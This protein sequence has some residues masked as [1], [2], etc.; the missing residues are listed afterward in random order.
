MFWLICSVELDT[1]RDVAGAPRLRRAGDR[2]DVGRDLVRALGD[3]GRALASRSRCSRRAGRR[4]CASSSDAAPRVCAFAA[5]SRI[6]LCSFDTNALKWVAS[7]PTSSSR[8]D[9]EAEGQVALAVLEV[10]HRGRHA[11]HRR[12]DRAAHEVAE[13]DHQR[14]GESEA[15]MRGHQV[16]AHQRRAACCFEK[17]IRKKP[18]NSP[19]LSTGAVTRSRPSSSRCSIC[20]TRAGRGCR[21]DLRVVVAVEPRAGLAVHRDA[22][23]LDRR[24]RRRRRRRRC[25]GRA[26]PS[27]VARRG[28]AA[29]SR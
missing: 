10:L 27:R 9:V 21:G 2:L 17:S 19:S 4:C 6:R 13:H 11:L 8:L 25:V 12:R 23:D 1:L 14:E 16:A 5:T 24:V 3:G 20:M 26:R 7:R 15:A 29:P 22:L 28:C 18:L